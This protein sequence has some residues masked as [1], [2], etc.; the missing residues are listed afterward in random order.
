MLL[1]TLGVA[2]LAFVVG[3]TWWTCRKSADA[4]QRREAIAEAWVNIFVGFSFNYLANLVLIPLM[5]EGGH[6]SAGS[7]FWGGCVYTAIS[8][9][10]Q[11]AIR[12]WFAT[13]LA[14]FKRLLLRMIP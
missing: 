5:S 8:M 4:Q 12:R 13:R 9:A 2:S 14:S 7:N 1:T 3:F 10:R 6:L 11:Y